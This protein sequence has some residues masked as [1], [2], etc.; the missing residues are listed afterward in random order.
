MKQLT[1]TTFFLLLSMFLFS[2][3]P[4][5]VWQKSLG[6]SDTDAGHQIVAVPGGGYI[7][8]ASTQSTDGDVGSGHGNYDI[9]LLRIDNAGTIQWSKTY[10]GSDWEWPNAIRP[11][12]DGGFIVVGFT[13]SDDGDIS[14]F[15]GF[16]DGWVFKVDATGN[17]QWERTLGSTAAETIRDV[18]VVADGY[19]LVGNEGSENNG[20]L[21]GMSCDSDFWIIKLNMTGE[22]LWQQC[23]GGSN[24][25]VP[26][27]ICA[28][29][30][31]QYL[32]T[33]YTGSDNGD[34]TGNHGSLDYWVMAIDGSGTMLWQKTL[35][36]SS[37]DEPKAIAYHEA[38][39]VIYVVG[40]SLSEDG[41]VSTHYDDLD[42]WVAKLDAT[43]NL[44]AEQSFGG[45]GEDD[46]EAI[47][48]LPNN[49]LLIAG[50][51]NS[52]DGDVIGNHGLSDVWVL[53]IDSDLNLLWNGS[54][55]GSLFESA[56]SMV[57]S[58]TDD[59]A[60]V[61]GHTTSFDGDITNNLGDDDLW[62]FKL[63]DVFTAVEKIQ[64]APMVTLFPNPTG[65]DAYLQLPDYFFGNGRILIS[66]M[67]GKMLID[68]VI[69]TGEQLVRINTKAL[70]EGMYLCRIWLNEQ[71]LDSQKLL[72]VH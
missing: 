26:N 53:K 2:Q 17:L 33:G 39:N 56:K 72:I 16:R 6:G 22:I 9:W 12:S 58:T 3:S 63:G 18:H 45:T 62:L 71:E 52:T 31:D 23:Y 54:F 38:Q 48:L 57:R 11:T 47:L 44:L 66:D 35:G 8:A 14:T 24:N 34:V 1:L 27:K 65:E 15:K 4:G 36:G 10:G 42:L 5:I 25:D 40:G 59:A 51:S 67:Q 7:I 46:A 70:P 13:Y 43:G 69:P 19:L 49:Q 41:D 21:Q 20:D 64:D 60:L 61:V 50:V 37:W 29:G 30:F 32:I 55:G 28:F 68:Q